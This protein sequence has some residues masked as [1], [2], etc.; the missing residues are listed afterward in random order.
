MTSKLYAAE[1]TG[2]ILISPSL[3]D[4]I[5]RTLAAMANGGWA[6]TDDARRLGQSLKPAR[7]ISTQ[8][9]YILLT[10]T[11][12]HEQSSMTDFELRGDK[13]RQRCMGFDLGQAMKINPRIDQNFTSFDAPFGGTGE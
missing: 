7:K 2:L 12:N 11:G 1:S 6:Y 13:P 4:Y 10:L 3:E 9:A 5:R 8:H